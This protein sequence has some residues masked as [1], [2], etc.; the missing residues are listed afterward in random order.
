MYQVEFYNE[1]LGLASFVIEGEEYSYDGESAVV[2]AVI[3]KRTDLASIPYNFDIE[4]CESQSNA[5]VAIKIPAY[6]RR[7]DE[8]KFHVWY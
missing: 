2:P 3:L 8:K 7:I 5:A 4:I 1:V 6:F